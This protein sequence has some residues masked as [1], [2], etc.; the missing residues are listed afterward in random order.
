[1]AEPNTPDIPLSPEIIKLTEK[2][3]KDPKSRLFVPLAEEYLK[4]GMLDEAMMVLKDGLKIHPTSMSAKTTLGKVHAEK[5]ERAE[6]KTIFEQLITVNPDNLLAHRKLAH[7]YK[8][9]GDL[10]RARVSCN[11]VL[12]ANPKD[13]AMNS[14]VEEIESAKPAASVPSDAA[15]GD[16]RTD[17]FLETTSRTAT[18]E[19]GDPPSQVIPKDPVERKETTLGASITQKIEGDK[20]S[21]ELKEESVGSAPPIQSAKVVEPLLKPS[22]Q[23]VHP[24][25]H[26]GPGAESP[27]KSVATGQASD[28]NDLSTE[29]L[30]DLY[31]K[32]GFYDKGLEIYRKI[33]EQYP[34]NESV[35]R[36]L[37]ETEAVMTVL[38]K[39]DKA[40]NHGASN[41]EPSPPQST[42]S[43]SGEIKESQEREEQNY[44]SEK[45]RRLEAWL[46]SI[47]KGQTQ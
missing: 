18:K 35:R 37:D 20:G 40:F 24:E 16:D 45:V 31:I 38:S 17:T 5:G 39:G 3:T 34:S 41:P 1:M 43:D 42:Q 30:A 25:P 23:K 32:Q 7:I 46:E 2:L 44:N 28:Q 36:K 6:A 27:E 4:V 13:A 19:K 47:R 14:L 29:S 8:D 12:M 15:S 10:E 33:I 11:A 26:Q 21:P 22:P 9:D